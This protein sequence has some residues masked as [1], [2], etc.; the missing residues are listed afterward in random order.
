MLLL[1]RLGTFFVL[2]ICLFLFFFVG[3][4]AVGGA[5]AGIRA[6]GD[7][8]EASDFQSGYKVG[9]QAGAAFAREYRG[10]IFFG[11]VATSALA[12]FT[13]SFLGVFPWCRKVTEP[14]PTSSP[15]QTT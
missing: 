6:G 10:A 2:F 12:S 4:L 13:L 3:S 1:K 7:H 11:A 15:P 8:P 9:E 14:P 5:A